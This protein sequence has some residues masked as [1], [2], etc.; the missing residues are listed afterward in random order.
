MLQTTWASRRRL[1]RSTLR[2]SQRAMPA[3]RARS[4]APRQASAC[5]LASAAQHRLRLRPGRHQP[6]H[7]HR[8]AVAAMACLQMEPG[9]TPHRAGSLER[10]LAK[11]CAS[12]VTTACVTAVSSVRI[13]YCLASARWAPVAMYIACRYPGQSRRL[14]H[15]RFPQ[16]WTSASLL[17]TSI[18]SQQ[19]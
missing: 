8:R 4:T 6:R 9:Q 11:R 15:R 14:L 18:D 3:Q 16:R 2:R 5:P 17:T 1:R 7:L 13:L 12:T 19:L 10:A